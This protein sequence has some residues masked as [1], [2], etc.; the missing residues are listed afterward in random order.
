MLRMTARLGRARRHAQINLFSRLTPARSPDNLGALYH[1]HMKK[2]LSAF[3]LIEL[4]VVITIIAILASIALPVF[5][6]V[7]ERANQTKDLS[8]AKEIGIALKLFAADNDGS[9]PVYQDP[10]GKT[11]A[12]T[13]ANQAFRELFPNYLTSEAI[14][15]VPGSAYTK[16]APDNNYDPNSTGGTYTQTLKAGENSFA[17]V[18][19]LSETSNSSFPLVADG[20]NTVTPPKYIADKTQ[21]GGVWSGK[22]AIVVFCDTS[23]QIMKCDTPT[24]VPQRT[25]S[26]GSKEAFSITQR[27]PLTGSAPRT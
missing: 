18:T 11:G 8:N 26:D 3:T 21:N 5:G 24:L 10:D 1:H 12:I 2:N 23:G 4:L 27:I 19:N 20:F 25:F 13:T 9:F 7:T 6:G 22:K 15:F 17:Y 14:F 16:V